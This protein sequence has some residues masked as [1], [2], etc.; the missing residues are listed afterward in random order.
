MF[1]DIFNIQFITLQFLVNVCRE[2]VVGYEVHTHCKHLPPGK[3]AYTLCK[4][5]QEVPTRLV[6]LSSSQVQ[7]CKQLHSFS[8]VQ[9][10]ILDSSLAV[11]Y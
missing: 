8:K 5:C 7:L 6:T 9:I 10:N 4:L 3:G 11:K 1:R 2:R